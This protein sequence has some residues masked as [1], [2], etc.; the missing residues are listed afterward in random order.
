MRAAGYGVAFFIGL[1]ARRPEIF[2]H[3][4]ASFR[5]AGENFER[6]AHRV[7][8]NR[9]AASERLNV[10]K[11]ESV[12]SRR[13]HEDVR[14]LIIFREFL[15]ELRS[16]EDSVF[17]LL[18]KLRALRPVS[19]NELRARKVEREEVFNALL[20]RQPTDIEEDRTRVFI[21]G[22]AVAGP[23]GFEVNAAPTASSS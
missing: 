8:R 6:P 2:V 20:N 9:H 19:D 4:T 23:E 3:R 15:A 21:K 10:N 13:E 7:C 18:L 14:T 1:H 12:R 22:R 11:A 5:S 16:D 17:I